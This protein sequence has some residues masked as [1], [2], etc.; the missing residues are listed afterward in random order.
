MMGHRSFL[1]YLA[2]GFFVGC[3]GSSSLP[4]IPEDQLNAEVPAEADEVGGNDATGDAPA[5]PPGAR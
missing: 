2:V 5:G 4:S 1:C 3:G